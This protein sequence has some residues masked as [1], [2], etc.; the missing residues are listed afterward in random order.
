M[1]F[2]L[3]LLLLSA[4][5]N[6]SLH[7]SLP[8]GITL[9]AN[10]SHHE[11]WEDFGANSLQES[12]LFNTASQLSL[13]SGFDLKFSG[14]GGAFLYT[15]SDDQK[16]YL[17]NVREASLNFSQSGVDL[18]VGQLFIP[19]GKTDGINPT[20][21]FSAKDYR[22]LS[23]EDLFRKRGFVGSSFG[24]T[25]DNGVS[26]VRFDFVYVHQYAQTAFNLSSDL[27]PAQT[28]IDSQKVTNQEKE[29]AT[30][31]SY[32]GSG[33][34]F[35]LS[36]FS[37]KN[38]FFQ[39]KPTLTSSGILLQKK[40]YNRQSFGFDFSK[41]FSDFVL[42]MEGAYSLEKGES[43]MLTQ[44]NH[45]DGVLGIERG[46]GDR[47]RL[48]AQI[49]FTKYESWSDPKSTYIGVSA[50]DTTLGRSVAFANATLLNYQNEM[51]TGAT[52]NLQFNS[53]DEL[54]KMELNGLYYFENKNA[55]F[56][57]LIAYK[58]SDLMKIQLGAEIYSGESTEPLGSLR[59]QSNLFSELKAFF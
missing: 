47:V 30:K 37:G 56:K 41:S 34:D 51:N 29:W 40:Y 9:G 11:G 8:E 42:R 57:P 22:F 55:L 25:P 12:I 27:I 14:A 15:P 38:H 19:W 18:S 32:T 35:S 13:G 53:V 43:E 3:I 4:F 28:T 26:P 20:D 39:F 5:L 10:L 17:G 46:F 6:E 16:S 50:T 21:Y 45:F 24:W 33:W 59:S 52:L 49:L 48:I 36:T 23:S 54:W 2:F 1:P 7:A 58:I 44:P 31:V